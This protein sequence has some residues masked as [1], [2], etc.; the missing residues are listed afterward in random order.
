MPTALL[1]VSDKTGLVDFAKGLVTLGCDR[2][3]RIRQ[4]RGEKQPTGRAHSSNPATQADS[5]SISAEMAQ[6]AD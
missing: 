5:R 1:S 2:Q 4:H 6:R 3:G